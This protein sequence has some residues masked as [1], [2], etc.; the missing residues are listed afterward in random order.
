ML[1]AFHS[2]SSF[3]YAFASHGPCTSAGT[4]DL[5][6]RSVNPLFTIL[7]LLFVDQLLLVHKLFKSY[8]STMIIE[9]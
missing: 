4:L 5:G 3:P 7:N 1:S 8:F 6:A 9:L 2:F